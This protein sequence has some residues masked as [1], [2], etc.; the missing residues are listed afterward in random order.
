MKFDKTVLVAIDF[1]GTLTQADLY[2]C[3]EFMLDSE[4]VEYAKKIQQAGAKIILWTCREGK[5]LKQAL[6]SLQ[7]V[8]LFF[9]Y[10][11]EGNVARPNSRKINADIYIDD[12]ANDG[13]LDWQAIYA[14]VQSLI[15][16]RR[17]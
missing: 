4:A 14:R 6:Q 3:P 11:N 10:V 1:D 12:K 9:D 13:V 5:V 17:A 16:E 15:K 8:G 2:P 7:N